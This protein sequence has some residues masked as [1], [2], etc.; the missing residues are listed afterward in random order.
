MHNQKLQSQ[1][2]N[3][4][5]KLFLLSWIQIT[6]TDNINN[7]WKIMQIQRFCLLEAPLSD[8][9]PFGF[10]KSAAE[11]STPLAPG[12]FEA[13]CAGRLWASL[14]RALRTTR[15]AAAASTRRRGSSESRA[16]RSSSVRRVIAARTRDI[17]FVCSVRVRGSTPAQRVKPIVTNGVRKEMKHRLEFRHLL[18][19]LSHFWLNQEFPLGYKSSNTD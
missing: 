3:S 5:E 12:W 17:S 4:R 19:T 18:R 15:C 13:A 2:I 7:A 10:P 16:R 14:Q 6:Q 8:S 9:F 11:D 1:I